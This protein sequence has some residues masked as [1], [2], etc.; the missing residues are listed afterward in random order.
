M[1]F[2]NTKELNEKPPSAV[3]SLK[4]N[5][6]RKPPLEEDKPSYF[7]V[8]L[9]ATETEK[10]IQGAILSFQDNTI[11]LNVHLQA[12]KYLINYMTCF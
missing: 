9:I 8:N 7:L 4:L 10:T 12:G 3:Q 6:D 11:T 1:F 2:L 5:Q